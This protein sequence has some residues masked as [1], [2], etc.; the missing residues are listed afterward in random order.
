MTRAIPRQR[1]PTGS[2]EF[3][4]PVVRVALLGIACA[5]FSTGCLSSG[6]SDAASFASV[7]I[8]GHTMVQIE[9]ATTAV[10]RAHEYTRKDGGADLRFERDGTR[11]DQAA[12]GG[13][14]DES[15]VKVRVR[16]QIVP[17]GAGLYR[18]QCRVWMVK[19]PGDSFF[20]EEVKLTSLSSR[21]YQK[22]LNEVASRLK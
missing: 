13:W 6:K 22:L 12:Y 11:T 8:S 18:L 16:A 19:N 10:F 3:G 7:V 20:E 4:F 9:E 5:V 1:F 21:P 17:L 15:R 2:R 14:L